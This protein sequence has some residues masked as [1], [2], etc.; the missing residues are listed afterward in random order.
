M[1][2]TGKVIVANR[3]LKNVRIVRKASTKEWVVKRKGSRDDGY[4]TTDI[5]DAIS[6]AEHMERGHVDGA[7]AA[8][9]LL[10]EKE[11]RTPRRKP[12]NSAKRSVKLNCHR[13]GPGQVNFWTARLMKGSK[14]AFKISGYDKDYGRLTLIIAAWSR[15]DSEAA[16]E[17]LAGK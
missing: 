8:N 17:R 6:T 1:S 13:V 11:Q 15:G 12:A 14:C 4:F 16:I 3:T 2:D 7:I 10:K 9:Q 5:D